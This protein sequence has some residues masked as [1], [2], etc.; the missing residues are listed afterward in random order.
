VFV[1]LIPPTATYEQLVAA[2]RP[3]GRWESIRK[4]SEKCAGSRDRWVNWAAD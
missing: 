3:Y 2:L 4:L 1:G